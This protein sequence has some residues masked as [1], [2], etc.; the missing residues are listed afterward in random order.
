MFARRRFHRQKAHLV[1]SAMRHRA[2]ELGDRCRYVRADTYGEALAQRRRAAVGLPPDDR[3]ARWTSCRR[4]TV[5]RCCRA[6]G[7]ATSLEDFAAWA[8]GRG[9][10]RLLMEDFYREARR[11]LDVL[12]DGTDP[13]GGRWNF[14]ADNREP[15]PKQPDPR[16]RRAVVA[17]RGR[18]RRRGA[19]T[20]STAGSDDGDVAFV[21]EDGPR[22]FA[23]TRTE[24][25]HALRDFVRHRL[26]T[27]GAH[28]DAMLA[29]DAWMAHSLLSAPMNLGLLDPLEVV[30]RA[31][32]AL[33]RRRRRRSRRSRGSSGR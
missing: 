7:F 30:A 20:T 5:S 1:L 11:R 31:E 6:R 24:A 16:R 29:G 19:R 22:R 10:R 12:M 4:R 9:R 2:A 33:P 28:E 14:D 26:P 27:F 23:A 17:G 18:D 3:T 32:Q 15:P 13:V 8:D 25:R 21:G